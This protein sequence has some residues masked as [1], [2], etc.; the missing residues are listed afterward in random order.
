M[1]A[2][3]FCSCWLWL[4]VTV[5]HNF[6]PV[7][8]FKFQNDPPILSTETQLTLACMYTAVVLK[9]SAFLKL[10]NRRQL[11][12]RFI[13]GP[14]WLQVGHG[15]ATMSLFQQV[16]SL[17]I[18]CPSPHDTPISLSSVSTVFLQVVLGLP[19]FLLPAGVY[20][21]ATL[22]ILSDDIRNTCPS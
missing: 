10:P 16:L 19:L 15:A 7:G 1:T 6:W 13:I 17:T 9:S 11:K 14:Y 20:P 18:D 21:R 8:T 3:V 5:L 2:T 22:G 12:I 4:W